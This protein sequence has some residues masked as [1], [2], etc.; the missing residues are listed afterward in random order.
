M[1]SLD[2]TKCKDELPINTIT[3][4]K[5]ILYKIGIY[6]TEVNWKNSAKNFH[7]VSVVIKDTNLSTNGKGTTPLYALASAYG[8]LMERLQNQSFFKL[9]IDLSPQILQYRGFYYA[10][11]EKH[12]SINDVLNSNDDWIQIQMSRVRPNIDRVELLR[13][14]MAIAYEDTHCDFVAL[15]YL[16]LTN[17]NLSYIPI[18]MISKMYM[19]NGM[20]AGNT[21]EEALVQGLSE[22]FERVVNRAIVLNKIIP[23]TIPLNYI[24]KFPRIE[25]MIREIEASGNY[26]VIVKDCSLGKN[27]PVVGVIFINQSDQ[28]YFIKFGSHPIFELAL[29]RTLTELLQGQ[30]IRN[31]KGVKEF[32]YK[33]PIDTEVNNLIGILVNGSGFYPTELFKEKFS[34]EFKEFKDIKG[35]SNKSM[36]TYLVNLLKK[37]GHD[38]FVRDASY[39]GFPSYHIVVPGFSEIEKIDDIDS[40]EEYADFVRIKKTIRNLEHVSNVEIEELLQL[41]KKRNISGPASIPQF[42]NIQTKNTFPWYYVTI[43]LFITAAYYK[44]GDFANAYKSF[45]KFLKNIQINSF[46]K[47]L[48][49]FYKCVRDYIGTRAD[50]LSEEECINILG[51]FYPLNMIKQIMSYFKNEENIFTIFGQLKCWNC[52][53]CDVKAS[54]SYDKVE[55]VYKILK[56]NYSLTKINQYHIKNLLDL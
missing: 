3:K 13:K 8:E 25:A 34:Y 47:D 45:D 36:L 46:N 51:T 1:N 43:D 52:N 12:M 11:D 31:M 35:W 55:N 29:E 9:S 20:C 27:Y 30:D 19:S 26:K 7:S 54:C 23:P 28:T 48:Y 32:S 56:Y 37:E 15:P 33:N 42:L 41:M 14:W 44:I 5:N 38:I 2:T 24:S 17:N 40:L 10:P 16:N 6:P 22:V 21:I 18:K 39:L 4:I 50:N 53:K 49:K